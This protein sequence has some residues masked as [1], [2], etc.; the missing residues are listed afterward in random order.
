M[1]RRWPCVATA[2]EAA[3]TTCPGRHRCLRPRLRTHAICALRMLATTNGV[4]YMRACRA[5]RY[6]SSTLPCTSRS[7]RA[8]WERSGASGGA[9]AG[10]C[11]SA[12]SRPGFRVAARIVALARDVGQPR[13]VAGSFPQHLTVG[14]QVACP[15]LGQ[16]SP[17]ARLPG[18]MMPAPAH[19]RVCRCLMHGL[20]PKDEAEELSAQLKKL[21]P[22]A[23]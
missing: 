7:P 20:L 21:K 18:M 13:R 17:C 4:C 19:R 6:A 2:K 1:A 22:Q 9:L 23:K 15:L 8:K 16:V 14:V 12:V 5:T 3:C 10:S 11:K